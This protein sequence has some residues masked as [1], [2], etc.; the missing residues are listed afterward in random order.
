MLFTNTFSFVG[1]LMS[2]IF[3]VFLSNAFITPIRTIIDIR[4][5]Q[6]LCKR[7][8]ELKQ[9]IKSQLTQKEANTYLD[10]F[11]LTLNSMKI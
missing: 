6:K 10:F 11:R 3:L 7:R 4:W 8:S 1:G 2:D 9:G 5:F